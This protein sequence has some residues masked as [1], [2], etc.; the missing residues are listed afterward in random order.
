[1]TAEVESLAKN[2]ENAEEGSK[3][4]EVQVKSINDEIDKVSGGKM[5]QV[6]KQINDLSKSIEKA[7]AEITKARGGIK[8][9]ERDI[10]NCEQQIEHDL[11]EVKRNEDRL[12]EINDER[13]EIENV[14]RNL[15]ELI[16]QLEEQLEERD[17]MLGGLREELAASQARES[18]MKHLKVEL[19]HKL[20]EKTKLL[21]ELKHKIPELERRMASTKLH[22]IPNTEVEELRLLN[23]EEMESLTDKVLIAKLQR[24]KERMPE[25]VPNLQLIR[26]YQEKDELYLKRA[27]ELDSITTERN[28]V[29]N[30]YDM[31]KRKRSSEFLCGF[32]VITKKLKE[33]YQMITLGGDAE[34]ELVDSID[35][36]SEG[37]VFS[38]RPPKKSWKN[39][40]NLSGGEKTL[41]SLALVFALHHYRPTPL[42]FMDE[43]DAAL[44][45]KNV[46]IVGHYINERTK[47]A[48]FIVISLRSNMFELADYMVG[49]YKT[50]NATKAVCLDL[51]RFYDKNGLQPP[52]QD[53]CSQNNPNHHW[54]NNN[55]EVA[56]AGNA[57][58]RQVDEPRRSD[59]ASQSSQQEQNTDEQANLS[60]RS[61]QSKRASMK[62]E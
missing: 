48:Q 24:A 15:T 29:R 56:A 5:K 1:M 27:E 53:L 41:S 46:S 8:S 16:T 13:K 57:A 19:D 17:Q 44:D 36:F 52:S 31:V 22:V 42:Y 55:Q 28:K 20:A 3:S 10:K 12:R 62:Y 61:S 25:E 30:S 33:M 49:I 37:V 47:N 40:N 43:I 6:Q 4:V 58:P 60:Q 32:D 9:A 38:V 35:P 39:I 51:S 21:K 11:N 26:E 23:E 59:V 50:H 2:L 7:K 45:F 34:L 14:A 18:K 54:A